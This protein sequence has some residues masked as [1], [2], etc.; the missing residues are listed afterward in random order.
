MSAQWTALISEFFLWGGLLACS[1]LLYRVSYVLS[2]RLWYALFPVREFTLEV[3][4]E[5]SGQRRLVGI[6]CN[7]RGFLVDALNQELVRQQLKPKKV[8]E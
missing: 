2:T 6:K 8:S 4:D 5:D 1:P 3:V 7:K